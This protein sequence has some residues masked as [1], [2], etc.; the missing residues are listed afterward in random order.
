MPRNVRARRAR[1]YVRARE[2][3]LFTSLSNGGAPYV[4]TTLQSYQNIII[5]NQY[6]HSDPG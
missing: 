3:G 1:I 5:G 2:F 6:N 4:N